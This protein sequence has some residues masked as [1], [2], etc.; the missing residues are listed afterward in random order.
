MFFLFTENS[1]SPL[2]ARK[3]APLFAAILILSAIIALV[4]IIGLIFK[5]VAAYKQSDKYIEKSKTRATNRSDVSTFAKNNELSEE[6]KN[7]LWAA[8]QATQWKNI[9]YS[10]KDNSSV[11]ELFKNAYLILK[12]KKYFTE[13]KLN[14]YFKTVFK[15]ETIVA[16]HKK[17]IS[18]KQLPV[19]TVINYVHEEG[20]KYP[21]TIAEN[22]KDFFATI[23][24][25]FLANSPAKPQ[26]LKQYRFVYKVEDG[27][28]FNFFTRVIRYEETDQ[29]E[30]KAILAHTD[31][32]EC[33]TL[34]KSKRNFVEK[35]C[36]FSAVAFLNN[37]KTKYKINEKKFSGKITNISG[38]GCCIK[39]S[40]NAKENQYLC[41]FLD[42]IGIDKGILGVIRRV[43]TLPGGVFSLHIQFVN[44]KLEIENKI[45]TLVYKY[46]S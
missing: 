29:N 8:C 40:V 41:V 22:S 13:K 1:G 7:I 28:S 35:A 18:S 16:Q 23:V 6:E 14:S 31:T 44:L 25:E 15:I 19:Q 37:D 12:E 4:V 10:L 38:G 27:L 32:F 9:L 20:E 36:Q 3:T 43:R 34:R 42:S 46:E 24:P 45:F 30:T 33:Q 5:S 21:L 17:I 11:N 39:S 26:I 2:Q